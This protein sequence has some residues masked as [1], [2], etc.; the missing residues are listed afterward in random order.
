MLLRKI[1]LE[2]F[3]QFNGI[4]EINFSTDKEK[5]VTLILGDNG[6]GKTTI[7]QAFHWCFYGETPKFLKKDS[8]LSSKIESSM[9]DGWTRNV[10]V[11]VEMSHDKKDYEIT[12]NKCYRCA[13]GKILGDTPSLKIIFTD[14]ETGETKSLTGKELENAIEEI[15]PKDLSEYFFL[16]AEKVT[17]MSTD[18]RGGKSKDFA[19]A[20]NTLLDLDYF[21]SAIKHL[22]AIIKDYDT[23]KFEGMTDQVESLNRSID[24]VDNNIKQFSDKI[25]NLEETK[26]FF[27]EKI[28]DIKSELKTKESSRDIEIERQSYEKKLENSKNNINIEIK[29][30][31]R[32]F[33]KKARSFFARNAM[34][35]ALE[36]LEQTA[37]IKTEEIP[38]RLHADLID[39]IEKN[40]R[41]ICG[42][43]VVENSAL[44]EKLESW[45]NIVPPESIGT[46]LKQERQRIIS[47]S[48]I[49][50]D[51][52][53]SIKITYDAIKKETEDIDEYE[54]KIEELT[55]KIA[56]AQD[57]SILQKNLTHYQEQKD[58]AEKQYQDC[59]LQLDKSKSI[60]SEKTKERDK[61]LSTNKEGKR[62]I[63]WKEETNKLIEGFRRLLEK[64]EKEKR[65]MLIKAVKEAFVK[66]YGTTFSITIEDDYHISTDSRLEK[67][68]GQGMAIIYS[69]LAGLLSVIKT[70]R[71]KKQENENLTNESLVLE[72]YPLVLDAAF[73]ALDKTRISSL[74]KVL[75]KVSEQI[76][77]FLFDVY[78]EQ[79]KKEMGDKIGKCY[80]LV[81]LGEKD[82]EVKIEEVK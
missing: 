11:C 32:D 27:D 56:N 6:S 1:V 26:K 33:I 48:K 13:A 68:D 29:S 61:I 21:K 62:I 64:E 82:D 12:R 2:N 42:S 60:Y 4:H 66:I 16:S 58:E 28:T 5:N 20:V 40:H 72:S 80:N 81:K 17:S 38:E 53:E 44:F 49:G 31:L 24:I 76:I 78:G 14:C 43:E 15:L 51:L 70:E 19:K 10:R 55:E 52:Y 22:N 39:W 25:K 9:Y 74:C 69:F 57:T 18:I 8:L 73:N 50:S 30:G 54:E 77:V 7:A 23:S 37:N 47:E 36:T 67:S 79:A 3:R 71:A 34:K 41:C 75:P 35:T 46:I 45:R 65:E 59:R 63:K